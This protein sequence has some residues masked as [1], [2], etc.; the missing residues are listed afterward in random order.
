MKEFD[1]ESLRLSVIYTDDLLK[2]KLR[3]VAK[4]LAQICTIQLI[5]NVVLFILIL[6]K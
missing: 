4:V 2:D 5:I 6:A 3:R 1:E